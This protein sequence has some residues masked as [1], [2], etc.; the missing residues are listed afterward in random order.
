MLWKYFGKSNP[1][2]IFKMGKTIF[3]KYDGVQ[4]DI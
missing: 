3:F 1:K 4:E 2:L